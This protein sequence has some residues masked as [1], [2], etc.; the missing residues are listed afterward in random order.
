LK[1]EQESEIQFKKSWNV[2]EIKKAQ[3][4]S[5][6][7]SDKFN[8]IVKTIGAPTLKKISQAGPEMQARLLA[9]LELKSFMITDGN[10][11]INLFNTAAGLIGS[12]PSQ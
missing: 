4:L 7:E 12:N 2:L 9:S 3:E 6:I 8:A 1:V 11:P 10:H 5:N